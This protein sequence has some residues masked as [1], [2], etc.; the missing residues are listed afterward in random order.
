MFDPESFGPPPEGTLCSFCHT[1]EVV[2][3]TMYQSG[4]EYRSVHYCEDCE[5][6]APEGC[7]MWHRVATGSEGDPRNETAA[8]DRCGTVGTI[9][10]VTRVTTIV[11]KTRYCR[12]CWPRVRAE[13]ERELEEQQRHLEAGVQAKLRD[14]RR[15]RHQMPP[16][17]NSISWSSASW[18]DT[19]EFLELLRGAA[20][21]AESA[22]D[23]AALAREIS[24]RAPD[25]DGPMP[26]DIVKFV[27]DHGGTAV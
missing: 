11:A 27:R 16:T 9:A 21:N 24:A 15:A 19:R 5:P 8:C 2:G 22:V 7:G 4:A 1:R 6:R 12:E 17:R 25:M 18:D 23:Y 3:G 26:P 14:P 20:S 13:L 10:C